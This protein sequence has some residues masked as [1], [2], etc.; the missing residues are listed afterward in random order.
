MALTK[1]GADAPHDKPSYFI[2]TELCQASMDKVQ[3][4]YYKVEVVLVVIV[5]VVV[6]VVVVGQIESNQ[7][8]INHLV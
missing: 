6:V 7:N 5:V 2:I 3:V 1:G 4:L 8:D